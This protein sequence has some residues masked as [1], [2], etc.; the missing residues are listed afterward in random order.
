MLRLALYRLVFSSPI[1][2]ISVYSR[3]SNLFDPRE[4]TWIVPEIRV[5]FTS[6]DWP[7]LPPEFKCVLFPKTELNYPQNFTSFYHRDFS[8]FYFQNLTLFYTKKFEHIVLSEFF[9]LLRPN[10]YQFRTVFCFFPL[11]NH[12]LSLYAVYPKYQFWNRM[13]VKIDSD[14]SWLKI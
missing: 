12:S 10:F 4:F 11:K 6:K 1:F 13:H 14:K 9:S 8:W 2:R 3:N 7:Q 5:C